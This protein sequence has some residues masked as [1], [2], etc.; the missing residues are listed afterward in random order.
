MKG[1]MRENRKTQLTILL[2]IEDIEKIEKLVIIHKA[3]F[4]SL[5]A[6]VRQSI[7]QFLDQSDVQEKIQQF[8]REYGGVESQ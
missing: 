3:K 2:P 4:P 6:V 7:Q 8:D 5:G 1:V